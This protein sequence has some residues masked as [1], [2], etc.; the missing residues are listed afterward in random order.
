MSSAEESSALDQVVAIHSGMAAERAGLQ[1]PRDWAHSEHGFPKLFV[2]CDMAVY[3]SMY[4][5]RMPFALLSVKGSSGRVDSAP[6]FG[7][8]FHCGGSQ[9]D[10]GP[11]EGYEFR[12][13]RTIS[14][15]HG[16]TSELQ[17]LRHRRSE[18]IVPLD[19]SFSGSKMNSRKVTDLDSKL[20]VSA[21]HFL[22]V[23][24]SAH[25]LVTCGLPLPCRMMTIDDTKLEHLF[26]IALCSLSSPTCSELEAADD[27]ACKARRIYRAKSPPVSEVRQFEMGYQ[28][29][30]R[31]RQF[32]KVHNDE[33]RFQWPS[34]RFIVQRCY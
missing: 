2:F 25:T 31:P 1:V 30:C 21:S 17:S 26:L 29:R 22:R 3:L 15:D 16:T 20:D 9:H 13:R 6:C 27:P 28:L 18:I 12:P 14:V 7:R 23:S 10:V 19:F 8:L 34:C 24:A 32:T 4:V 33:A 11:T 5:E